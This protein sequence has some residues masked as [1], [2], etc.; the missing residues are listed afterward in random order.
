MHKEFDDHMVHEHF[1]GDDNASLVTTFGLVIHSMADGFALGSASYAST[2]ASSLDLIIFVAL[3]M[4]KCPAAIGLVT[5]LMHETQQRLSI[6]KHLIC[7]TLSSPISALLTFYGFK[8]FSGKASEYDLNQNMVY[9]GIFLLISA[10]TF[11]YVATIHILPEVYCNTD[12]HRPHTHKHT[13]EDH[14][15]DHD[16]FAKPFELTGMIFGLILPF[17][18]GLIE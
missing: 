15:H 8:I 5:F 6:F 13:P 4:H 3:L 7:F 10:G 17:V 2:S 16:H 12:I 11:L 14:I 18:I 1:H 9:V